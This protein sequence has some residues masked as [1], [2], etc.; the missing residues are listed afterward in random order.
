MLAPALRSWS[1]PRLLLIVVIGTAALA[2]CPRRQEPPPSPPAPA[3][4]AKAPV[5]D[6]DAASRGEACFLR[7]LVAASDPKLMV[8]AISEFHCALSLAPA[9]ASE[10]HHQLG[11]AYAQRGDRDLAIH[12][13]Q[14]FLASQPAAPQRQQVE[15]EIRRLQGASR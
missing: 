4:Q 1:S 13:Y 5:P 9:R 2:A 6:S 14:S 11:K 10:A 12:H 3:V 7:G 8:Q 15:A